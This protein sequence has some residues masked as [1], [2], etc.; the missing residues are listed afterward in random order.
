MT[1]RGH[2]LVDAY[3]REV[4]AL[5]ERRRIL[6]LLEEWLRDD[7]GNFDAVLAIIKGETK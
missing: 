7:Y 4:G 3:W 5:E 2:H 6:A 1:S